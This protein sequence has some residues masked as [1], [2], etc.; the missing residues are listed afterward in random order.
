MNPKKTV[1]V[2]AGPTAVGKTVFAIEVAR[3]LQTEIIS[4]DSRQC[5]R[6][7]SI[8]VARPSEEELAAVPHH[9]IASHSI[10]DNVNAATFEQY[11]L[12]KAS[13]LFKA[14]D[15][16]VM[17]GGT[18]LYIR[19]FLEGLDSVP[20]IPAAIR[21]SILTDY[22]TG[23]LELLQEQLKTS[24]PLFFAEG[25]VRNPHRVMRALE[26][27]RATGQSILAFHRKEKA[28]RPFSV[29][30]VCL[31]LP[32]PVLY[33]RINTRVD[34][35]MEAGLLEEV[36]SV[37]PFQKRNALQTVGY[38]ELFAYLAGESTLE[39]AVT[40]IKTATRHYAKRQLTWFRNQQFQPLQVPKI[41]DIQLPN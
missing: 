11:A 4:A 41:E 2:I 3:Y 38:K 25:E 17:S 8:G 13:D 7:L 24:D 22:E 28:E 20:E 12:T 16:I 36:K 27:V 35:M 5:F 34:A 18:G 39:E 40:Q 33:D 10:H 15:V 30:K 14:K 21:D 31:E 23:G 32:R 37:A 6:E 26:V 29:I 1:I 9:F 19:A